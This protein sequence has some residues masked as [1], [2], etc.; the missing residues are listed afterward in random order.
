MFVVL[1]SGPIATGKTAVAN[2]LVESLDADLLRVR[3]VLGTVLGLNGRD[4]RT[5]QEQ[6]ADLDKRTGGRWLLDYID[7]HHRPNKAVVV[8]ALRTRRQTAPILEGFVDSR[9]V[10]LEAHEETRRRRYAIGAASDPVKAS[11]GL[12]TAMHHPTEAEV[13]LLRPMAH[14]VIATDALGINEVAAEVLR[15]LRLR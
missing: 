6:G 8:D 11:V 12:D 15:Q 5:L 9:L 10:Y 14:V 13:R 2:A 3:E 1:V 7:D 4:R